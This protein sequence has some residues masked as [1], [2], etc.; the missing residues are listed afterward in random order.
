[1]DSRGLALAF[2]YVEQEKQI[3]N[4][5][6]AVSG[7]IKSCYLRAVHSGTHF[8]DMAGLQLLAMLGQLYLF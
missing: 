2:K 6:V 1:M 8:T 7:L 3:L 5:V 4:F